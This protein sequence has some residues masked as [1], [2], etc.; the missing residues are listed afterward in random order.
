MLNDVELSILS[1]LWRSALAA[2]I[3]TAIG[4]ERRASGSLVRA[5]ILAL[6][7]L[8]TTALTAMSLQIPLGDPTRI[9]A[10]VLTGVG[11][12]GAGLIMRD[13]KGEV[14]GLTTAASLWAITGVSIAIGA[15]FVV[16]GLLL[17]LLVYFV[18]SW[19]E[20]PLFT[21]LRQRWT[22]QREKDTEKENI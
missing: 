20:W 5:R 19:N 7:A 14:R 9:P 6:V 11:F 12:L 10:G 2:L 17:A 3:G 21:R 8:S 22:K 13:A 4:W 1:V 15:G 18:I 16:L